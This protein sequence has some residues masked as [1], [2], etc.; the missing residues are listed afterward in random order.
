MQREASIVVDIVGRVWDAVD[1]GRDNHCCLFI[2][3]D[4]LLVCAVHFDISI[5]DVI[6]DQWE[7]FLV[8]IPPI[9]YRF[10]TFM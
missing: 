7:V 2:R 3:Y 1:L 5:L 9:K 4:F 6:C 10:E 8:S